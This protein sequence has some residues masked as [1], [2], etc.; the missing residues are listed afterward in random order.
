M[1]TYEIT[2]NERSKV[3]KYLLAFLSENK[4]YI[5]LNNPAKMTEEE[6]EAKI[7]KS[8]EQYL[9]GEYTEVLPGEFDKFWD[10]LG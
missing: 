9:R 10:S 5:K 7:Q 1:T 2:F 3:G 8:K 4:K 6:F